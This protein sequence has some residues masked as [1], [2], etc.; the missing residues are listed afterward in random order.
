[1]I[2]ESGKLLTA[3]QTARLARMNSKERDRKVQLIARRLRKQAEYTGP[4]KP[5]G[6]QH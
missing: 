1:M 6:P 3:A 5:A 2:W 4:A